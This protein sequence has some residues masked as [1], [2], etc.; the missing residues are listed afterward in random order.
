MSDVIE[1]SYTGDLLAH[2]RCPRAWAYETH[3]GFVPYEQVQAIEGRLLHH[4]MEWMSRTYREDGKLASRAE[5]YEQ[6][7]RF[8]RILRSRGITTSF[9]SRQEVLER[10]TGNLF[11]GS[12]LR[13]PVAAAIRGAEHTEYELRS[14]R[15]VLKREFAGKNRILLTGIIDL[16]LQQQDPL[17]YQQ[18]W[19]WENIESLEGQAESGD[20]EAAAGDREIWDIK[21]SRIKTPYLIDYVR[22][23]ISYAALFRERTG[24]LP[25]RCVLFFVNE[26]R[27]EDA[28]LSIPVDDEVVDNGLRWTVAQ[29]ADLQRTLTSFED[30]PGAVAGGTVL[31]R[32]QAVGDRVDEVLRT[33][34][35]G[36]AQRFD[37]EEY[38]TH[39][40][41]S[42]GRVKNDVSLYTVTK[43]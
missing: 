29:V 17:T 34:C 1:V 27:D 9:A 12:G 2:R 10:I 5:V 11:R 35:T 30:D 26:A 15:K 22:Q 32:D 24:A 18:V 4:A 7:E 31:R 25:R 43:N 38:T 16:V 41:S 39:L 20:D 3:A 42:A 40:G 8:Y 36:C 37:C 19:R 33:Q 13:K 14:V 21:G 6:L 28:L 23:V